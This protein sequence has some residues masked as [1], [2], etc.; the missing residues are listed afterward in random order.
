MT[1]GIRARAQVVCHLTLLAPC[2]SSPVPSEVFPARRLCSTLGMLL[3]SIIEMV[4]LGYA[5]F[6]GSASSC[7]GKQDVEQMPYSSFSLFFG[8]D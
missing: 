7:P 2:T 5:S 3:S 8:V 1:F 4:H 6:W